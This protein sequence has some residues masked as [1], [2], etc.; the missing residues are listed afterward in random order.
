MLWQDGSKALEK[1]KQKDLR[2]DGSPAR[3]QRGQGER[4]PQTQCH[5]QPAWAM[6]EVSRFTHSVNK[7]ELR[8]YYVPG[9]MPGTGDTWQAKL[10]MVLA[11]ME[12]MVHLQESGEKLTQKNHP[13]E[14]VIAN[15][16]ECPYRRCYKNSTKDQ[17]RLGA[18]KTF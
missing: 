9:I 12:L 3:E 6:E 13:N 11:F 7:Y 15:Q 5:A 4:A 10:E 1:G 17:P 14:H 2:E 8:A 18:R 16:D